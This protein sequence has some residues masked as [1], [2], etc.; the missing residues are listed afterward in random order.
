MRVLL[1]DDNEDNRF[2]LARRLRRRGMEV[3]EAVDGL[4]V[5]EKVRDDR[6]DVVLMDVAMPR[7]DGI[8]AT[9][10]IRLAQPESLSAVIPVIALTANSSDVTRSA[11]FEA[12]CNAFASK[13]I[14]FERLMDLLETYGGGR[15]MSGTA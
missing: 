8:A 2:M 4:D 13:P 3:I 10:A 6:P 14:D 1:A 12:G 11:C 15:S 7:M 5:L 9:R